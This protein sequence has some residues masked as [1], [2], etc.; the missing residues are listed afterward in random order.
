M[1]ESRALVPC[2]SADMVWY[3]MTDDG[4]QSDPWRPLLV[5]FGQPCLDHPLASAGRGRG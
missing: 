4:G 3:E 2:G 5:L 1:P